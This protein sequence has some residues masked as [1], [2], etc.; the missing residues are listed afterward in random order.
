MQDSFEISKQM[1]YLKYGTECCEKLISKSHILNQLNNFC[2][3]NNWSKLV[4]YILKSFLTLSLRRSLSQSNHL[5]IFFA[6]NWFLYDRDR[7]QKRAV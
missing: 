5:L 3:P 7:R 2:Y 4:V 6:I 1:E